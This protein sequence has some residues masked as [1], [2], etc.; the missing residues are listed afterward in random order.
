MP[1]SSSQGEMV[2]D[3]NEMIA[4]YENNLRK[5]EADVENALRAIC[6]LRGDFPRYELQ[7]NVLENIQNAIR[8]TWRFYNNPDVEVA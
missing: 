1:T 6:S 7:Y 5:A 8:G 2:M 3:K 4:E